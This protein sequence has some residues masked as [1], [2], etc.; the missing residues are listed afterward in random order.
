M[1]CSAAT[2]RATKKNCELHGFGT[3]IIRS[4]VEK[5]NGSIK[6]AMHDGL[7][8]TDVMLELKEEKAA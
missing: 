1:C 7:F 4:I 6:Y 3:R 2:A 5:Y 8:I